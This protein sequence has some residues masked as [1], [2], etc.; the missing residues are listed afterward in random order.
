VLPLGV[1]VGDGDGVGVGVGGGG[2]GGGGDGLVTDTVA[3]A[4]ALPA[5][6][7]QVIRYVVVELGPTDWL[8][9]IAVE[10]VHEAA[11]EVALVDDQLSLEVWPVVILAGLAAKVAV[12]A[13]LLVE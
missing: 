9:L 5:L 7:L 6:P 13:E 10:L 11:Q 1:G 4:V 2:G 8:P 12:G 3:T